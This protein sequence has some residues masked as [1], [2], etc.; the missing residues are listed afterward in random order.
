MAKGRV[1]I[2]TDCCKGCN[3]CVSVCPVHIL[4]LD[5]E[6]VNKIGYHPSTV[7]EPDKCIGCTF[8]ATVCPDVCISV[9]R[10]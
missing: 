1:T 8:C 10:L 7:V 6:K 4:E 3:L 9:E 5:N 2:S